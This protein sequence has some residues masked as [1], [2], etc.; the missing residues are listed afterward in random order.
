MVK[1]MISV[2]IFFG[3][4]VILYIT[5]SKIFDH[6]LRI[7]HYIGMAVDKARLA[8]NVLVSFTHENS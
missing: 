7:A 4:I 6:P 1:S 2:F 5:L 3:A 8:Y